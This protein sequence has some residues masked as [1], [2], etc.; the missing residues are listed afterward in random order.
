LSVFQDESA[1]SPARCIIS[2]KPDSGITLKTLGARIEEEEAASRRALY[3]QDDRVVDRETGQ[4]KT[5]RAGYSNPDP[6]YDGRGHQYTI[7][8]SPRSG[9]VLSPERIEELILEHA[10]GRQPAPDVSIKKASIEVCSSEAP[11]DQAIAEMSDLVRLWNRENIPCETPDIA[12]EV[13]IS[14]PRT[15]IAWVEKHI[16]RPLSGW[17]GPAKVFFDK[18][19]L[20][21]GASWLARLADAVSKCRVFL[22]IYCQDYFMSTFCAWELQLALLRDPTGDKRI[23]MPLVLED[24]QY[25]NYCKLIQ[26]H[27]AD[28]ERCEDQLIN[29]LR[30]VL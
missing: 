29:L 5:P 27:R 7:L 24:V 21:V 22:P 4:V 20:E 14:Y 6:W 11:Q 12:P 23:V 10:P 2:V 18:R 26:G 30:P 9:T 28:L 25:P 13:F 1:L 19:S 17:R 3:G 15:K 16:A 8:D